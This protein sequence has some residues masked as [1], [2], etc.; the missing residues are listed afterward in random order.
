MRGEL[1][2]NHPEEKEKEAFVLN[3]VAL[4]LR[5]WQERRYHPETL[6]QIE[7]Q[8]MAE[9]IP[10]ELEGIYVPVD[11][12]WLWWC[13]THRRRA[14]HKYVKFRYGC[15][16]SEEHCCAPGQSGIMMPCECVN[17]TGIAEIE[18]V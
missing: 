15:L 12:R 8:L 10:K 18:E 9:N 14:T 11:L 17:L 4:L 5:P 16:L 2:A 1:N 13:N 3:K 6:R 7:W